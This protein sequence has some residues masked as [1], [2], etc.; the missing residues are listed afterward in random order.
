MWIG[1]H[2]NLAPQALPESV[3]EYDQRALLTFFTATV[4]IDVLPYRNQDGERGVLLFLATVT[5]VRNGRVREVLFD[6]QTEAFDRGDRLG[7]TLPT[8]AAKDV[9]DRKVYGCDRILKAL[10]HLVFSP[11][12]RSGKVSSVRWRRK[13]GIMCIVSACEI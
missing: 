11:R 10:F 2:P 6:A 8:V 12:Y 13:A 4:Y 3:G 5:V 9:G 7:V 1:D